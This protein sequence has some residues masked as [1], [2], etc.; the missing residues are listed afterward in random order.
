M[1]RPDLRHCETLE[2]F[3]KEIREQQSNAHG[4]EYIAHH[5]ALRTCVQDPDVNIAKELGVCQGGTLAAMMLA[6][7]KELEGIDIAAHY[8][9][10][11]KSL[12]VDYA[13]ENNIDFSF[14]E[15]SSLS[16]RA[17]Y[18]CDLLHIDSLHKPSHLMNEL[19]L[20]APT[21]SK[22]IVFH[23]TANYGSNSGLLRTIVDYITEV[24]QSWTIIDHYTH[25]V[26]YTVIKR[27]ERI[28]VEYNDIK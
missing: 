14:K 15:T 17:I 26:G 28:P 20:H 12:F 5:E 4:K 18:E 19:V 24:E 9:N 25:S 6:H 8:F 22:Y 10:P 23:D 3:Y 11:Y 2:Q 27:E 1:I 13:K 7:P 16:K 21:V